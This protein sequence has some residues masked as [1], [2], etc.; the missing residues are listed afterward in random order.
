MAIAPFELMRRGYACIS[1]DQP[2]LDDPIERA[3]GHFERAYSEFDNHL[4]DL[5]P[6]VDQSTHYP[7]RLGFQFQLKLHNNKPQQDRFA[8]IFNHIV[9]PF[10]LYA[11][12]KCLEDTERLGLLIN[13]L[14]KANEKY[15]NKIANRIEWTYSHVRKY[16]TVLPFLRSLY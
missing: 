4:D 11:G 13:A 2:N 8:L 5:F 16:S 14:Q 9:S 7:L 10:L 12:G 15:K 1:Q 3:R 6:A